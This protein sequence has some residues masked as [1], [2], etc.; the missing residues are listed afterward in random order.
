MEVDMCNSGLG[1]VLM[2]DGH[3]IAFASKALDEAQGKYATIEKELLAVC[4]SCNRF[5]DYIFGK[6]ITVETDNKPLVS[7]MVKPIHKLPKQ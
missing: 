4:F 1:S 5:H 7:I 3:P 2:Q 6:H